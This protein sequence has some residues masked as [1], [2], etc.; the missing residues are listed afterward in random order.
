MKN[1]L[2]LL[3]NLDSNKHDFNDPLRSFSLCTTFRSIIMGGGSSRK[4][5]EFERQLDAA[6]RGEAFPK[7]NPNPKKKKSVDTSKNKTKNN[8]KNNTPTKF[9][10]SI[11]MKTAQSLI[12][13]Y[14]DDD[15][16]R[17]TAI[18]ILFHHYDRD[19]S[20]ELSSSE[21]VNLM[22]ELIRNSATTTT[23]EREEAQESASTM[24]RFLD[25]DGDAVLEELEFV[26]F[27]MS[28]MSR[29]VE[30]Q[31][32]YAKKGKPQKV[33]T[34]FLMHFS[35]RVLLVEQALD[36][37]FDKK[38]QMDQNRF[39]SLLVAGSH[40]S[41]DRKRKGSALA[42]GMDSKLWG[43]AVRIL[44]QKVNASTGRCPSKYLYKD[45]LLRFL[46]SGF[47]ASSEEAR[48]AR[49]P[50]NKCRVRRPNERERSVHIRLR[51][52]IEGCIIVRLIPIMERAEIE[53]DE[54]Y[55]RRLSM[56]SWFDELSLRHH[57][58]HEGVLSSPG[59]RKL[60]T[61]VF[62]TTF[63]GHTMREEEMH[64]ALK[65]IDEDGDGIISRPEFLTFINRLLLTRHTCTAHV[66]S[67]TRDVSH[68]VR[69]SLLLE[70]ERRM[71]ICFQWRSVL[72]GLFRRFCTVRDQTTQELLDCAKM[73][74]DQAILL[75]DDIQVGGENGD[76]KEEGK[77]ENGKE[78]EG[79]K[80][81]ARELFQWCYPVYT[82]PPPAF[83]EHD[84]V[85]HMIELLL[86]HDDGFHPDITKVLKIK[87]TKELRRRRDHSEMG[88]KGVFRR[89]AAMEKQSG[90]GS[91]DDGSSSSGSTK[92]TMAAM[93]G[94]TFNKMMLSLGVQFNQSELANLFTH[95]QR[96]IRKR[97]QKRKNPPTTITSKLNPTNPETNVAETTP[98]TVPSGSFKSNDIL[99]KSFVGWMSHGLL[100]SYEHR[101]IFAQRSPIHKKV[102]QFL[103]SIEKIEKRRVEILEEVFDSVDAD[104][105]GMI[106]DQ[107]LLDIMLSFL[108]VKCPSEEE[109]TLIDVREF[110]DDLDDN[111]DGWLKRSEFTDFF[112]DAVVR[113]EAGDESWLERLLQESGDSKRKVR[114]FALDLLK[115]LQELRGLEESS[116]K[117]MVLKRSRDV[118][119]HSVRAAAKKREEERRREE[120]E[121]REEEEAREEEEKEKTRVSELEEEKK[122]VLREAEE[123]KRRKEEERKMYFAKKEEER[124]R[125]EEEEK[126]GVKEEEERQSE[127]VRKKEKIMRDYQGEMKGKIEAR[128]A[129]EARD[130]QEKKKKEK[131]EKKE[132]KEKEKEKEENHR[133]EEESDDEHEI[134]MHDSDDEEGG[135]DDF[136]N[137]DDFSMDSKDAKEAATQ[138]EKKTMAKDEEED[139][140]E[141]EEEHE[142]VMIDSEDDEDDD[143][144]ID[145]SDV[146]DDDLNFVNMEDSFMMIEDSDDD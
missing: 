99:E 108:P 72:Q 48:L 58:E 39:V 89:H 77:E 96:K 25:T 49:D 87:V 146:E 130:A 69:R 30:T 131:K 106:H 140:E 110:M 55:V 76:G 84:F 138:I 82:H 114:H 97:S 81:L 109:P 103:T 139:E 78:G 133:Q 116:G 18:H 61:T 33:L 107:A 137:L 102:I 8:T 36:L 124:V 68:R 126:R 122:K 4:A 73:D 136:F 38:G 70:S 42:W 86:S 121:K 51:D 111:R 52:I 144:L 50:K 47:L 13:Q 15:V 142:I 7:N 45:Y 9:E 125:T 134:I 37:L 100:L 75:F 43:M 79:G 21:L 41:A 32:K 132:E 145:L 2:C 6:S 28:G 59:M 127:I 64:A 31:E 1:R 65:L 88:L 26:D 12:G 24:L 20:R 95:I 91:S 34:D 120:G 56:S 46:L 123:E 93:N 57:D 90:G 11:A 113:L 27:I 16:Y 19:D 35:K 135:G 67:R 54:D 101:L 44:N 143:D 119:D 115:G 66:I 53:A 10:E 105:S 117:R 129:Q 128:V 17:R 83:E 112:V 14:T 104:G 85:S 60:M 3:P 62:A 63:P 5:T 98:V 40:A 71:E 74:E 141:N 94:D 92:T 80:M 118:G 29:S 23:K 22:L